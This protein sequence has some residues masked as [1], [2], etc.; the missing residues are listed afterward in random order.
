[1]NIPTL[2]TITPTIMKS[3]KREPGVCIFSVDFEWV[4]GGFRLCMEITYTLVQSCT[5]ADKETGPNRATNGNYLN[6][7]RLPWA[8]QTQQCRCRSY[9]S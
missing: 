2:K 3:I 1:M 9:V 5:R 8:G 7:A 6:M 4:N